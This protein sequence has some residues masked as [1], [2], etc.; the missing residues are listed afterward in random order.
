[1]PRLSRARRS[2]FKSM[3]ASTPSTSRPRS[4]LLELPRVVGSDPESG[5]VITAQNGRY[6]PYLKKGTD[7][8]DRCRASEQIFD[9][10]LEE[11]LARLRAAEVRR[12][13]RVQRAQGVRADPVSGKPIK[14]KDGRFGPV[15]HGR[16][17]ERDASRRGGERGRGHLRARRPAARRRSGPKG[18]APKPHD[19]QG[20][21][22]QG[23]GQEEVTSGPLGGLWVTPR[24]RRRLRQDHPG[25]TACRSGSRP[26]GAPS[27]APVKPGGTEVGTLIRDI[28]LH[29]RGDIAPRAEALLYAADRAHHIETLVRPALQRGEVVIQDRYLDSSVA[30]QGAGRVLGAGRS[31]TCR[32]GRPEAR[33]GGGGGGGVAG[34]HRVLLDLDPRTAPAPASTRTTSPSIASESEKTEFHERVPRGLSSHCAAAE[35]ERFLVLD[36]SLPAERARRR[37]TRAGRGDDSA[38]GSPA[39]PSPRSW[40]CPTARLGWAHGCRRRR[41]V[42]RRRRVPWAGRVGPDRGDRRPAGGGI[43]SLRA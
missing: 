37:R 5:D 1:M 18:P 10:T 11:A 15:R 40:S 41:A 14:L 20:A 32:C 13:R 34:C 21:G 24:G 23:A 35:P 28:V 8:R 39:D 25:R 26:Q 17:N 36:A 12:T 27:S 6:G 3:V 29:H 33:G 19:P 30:Y 7:S 38:E 2:L 22:P 31:A 16:R 4:R 9:I 42:D 43:R